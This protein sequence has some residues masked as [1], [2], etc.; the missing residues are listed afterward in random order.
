MTRNGHWHGLPSAAWDELQAVVERFES[1]W[2]QDRPARIED[3]LPKQAAQRLPVLV[4]LVHVDLELHFKAGRPVRVEDYLQRFPDLT[5]EPQLVAELVAAEYRLRRGRG[6]T[7]P[8]EEYLDRFPAHGDRLAQHLT[9]STAAG[10][11]ITPKEPAAAAAGLPAQLGHYLVEGEIARGGMGQVVRLRDEEFQRPLAMK[12]LLPG[13]APAAELAERFLRE[14]RLTGQLQHPGV[15]PVHELGHLPDGRPYFVMKLIKGHSLHQLLR[16]RLSRDQDLTRFVGIFEQVCQTLA[17]AHARGI[18]HRDLKP[19]NVMV[20]A[21]GEVQVMDWGLA[22]VLPREEAQSRE[23]ERPGEPTT[24]FGLPDTPGISGETAAGA[25]LGTLAYMA[26]EQA[27]GE[28]DRLDART[29]V[30]GLGAILCEV[31]TGRPPFAGRS[32]VDNHRKAMHGELTDALQRLDHCGADAELVALA[33]HCLAAAPDD[34]P[35]HAGAVAAAVAAYRAGVQE[36]LR[37]AEI[38]RAAADVRAAE[39]RKRRRVSRALAGVALLLVLAVAGG[40]L[41]YLQVQAAQL[42]RAELAE[43]DLEALLAELDRQRHDLHQRLAGPLDAAQL[44]G[45]I[46]S[47]QTRVAKLRDLW[48]RADAVWQSEQNLL[49]DTWAD[50]LDMAERQVRDEEKY[51]RWADRLDRLQQESFT[52]VDGKFP[53]ERV[54]NKY[55]AAFRAM[56]LDVQAGEPAAVAGEMTR[57]PVRHVLVAALDHWAYLLPTQSKVLPRVLA[58]ARRADP[59]PWQDRVR[60][61]GTWK[62][63][64][65]LLQLAREAPLE[66][67]T[68]QVLL[69]LATKLDRK[70]SGEAATLLRRALARHPRSFWLYHTLGILALNPT[71]A[72]GY[73]RT[74]VALRPDSPAAHLL[75]GNALF[76]QKDLDG[77]AA[78]YRAVLKLDPHHAVALSNLGSATFEKGDIEGAMRFYQKA[79]RFDQSLIFPVQNLGLIHLRKKEL[80]EALAYYQKA[81][82]LDRNYGPAHFGLGE[83][84]QARHDPEGALWHFRKAVALDPYFAPAHL[85]LANALADRRDLAGAIEHYRKALELDAASAPAC[86]GLG[87]ALR[88]QGDLSEAVFYYKKA[89]ALDPNSAPAHHNLGLALRDRKDLPGAIRHLRKAVELN[90][91]DVA[92]R[93]NLSL[94]LLDQGDLDGAI[95]ECQRTIE[96]DPKHLYAHLNLGLALYRKK[97]RKGAIE[98]YRRAVAIDPKY[99]LTRNNLGAT[100]VE[101]RDFAGAS[102]Q[103]RQALALDPN[104]AVAHNGLGYALRELG[105]LDGAIDHYRRALELDPSFVLAHGNLGSALLQAKDL[106]GAAR[107]FRKAVALDPRY[108]AAY[109]GLGEVL[110][111][112]KEFDEAILQFKKAIALDVNYAPARQGLDKAMRASKDLE[113]SIAPYEKAVARNP[114]SAT[115]HCNLGDAM[116]DR[117]KDLDGA[118]RHYQKAL[119]LDSDLIGALHGLGKI[120]YVKKDF[121]GATAQWQKVLA[122]D[123]NYAPA[124][125]NL[126]N[127]L[128]ARKDLNGAMRHYEKALAANPRL[129]AARYNLGVALRRKNDLDGAARQYRRAIALDPKYVLAHYSLGLVLRDQRDLA[130]ARS[131]CEKTL[132]LDPTHVLAYIF[133]GHVLRDQKDLD[134][135]ARCYRKALELDPRAATAHNGLGSVLLDRQDF[136]GAAKHFRKAIELDRKLTS[137]HY[138]LGAVLRE[139]RDL[140]GA[141]AQLR[142][143]LEVD[144][145]YFLAHYRLGLCLYDTRDFEGAARHYRRVIELNPR[146]IASHNS[147]GNTLRALGD[148]DGAAAAYRQALVIDPKYAVAHCNLG[149]I[150]S[151]RHDLD[152]AIRHYR[153]AVA[154]SPKFAMAHCNLGVALQKQGHF[155]EALKSLLE[156]HELGSRQ[157]DWKSPSGQWVSQCR[158]LLEL[159][160]KLPAILKGNAEP[161]D[162]AELLELADLCWRYKQLHAAAARFYAAAFAVEPQRATAAQRYRAACCAALAASGHGADAGQLPDGHKS[163]WRRQALDWLRAELAELTRQVAS[164]P[165]A[166]ATVRRTLQQWQ[167][168]PDLAGVR[169]EQALAPLPQVERQSW[170][171]FWFEV[172]GLLGRP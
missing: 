119:E 32:N 136:P 21:F 169:D 150:L 63:Q 103:Y 72:C 67:V 35:R 38:D 127:I 62:D 146:H 99:A 82:Q 135:A 49:P 158:R 122:R 142:R 141:I 26:P 113:A 23:C 116:L 24:V 156:G 93:Y 109:A 97:D 138:N 130:G 94:A 98:Y 47:W 34:R 111:A 162:A 48:Q 152:G 143:T 59:G 89:V 36:R 11:E 30:F 42:R 53:Y 18:I 87:N 105:D 8:L 54:A 155:A 22:K 5:N 78:E 55:P 14:A 65:R 91:K 172:Q 168:D 81:L 28:V 167:S 137:A 129:I 145:N 68:P 57:L 171:Q 134:G 112:G 108:T 7:P 86:L 17:Y 126:G 2:E 132:E 115:A 140:K 131:A 118:L 39:E 61:A 77:A 37:R 15:P 125:Y 84:C 3:F 88:T 148:L 92:G 41:W 124:H 120:L 19:L 149:V 20:G 102:E 123:P 106:D 163:R 128:L 164:N 66:R 33:K 43:R 133:L 9:D 166:A 121:D 31:L 71:E 160:E 114:Q 58:V 50:R 95:R 4:E 27:R 60:N 159:D 75:V 153:Q 104:C 79:R 157:P 85:G 56:G 170:Q 154:L 45:D 74:A 117:K 52:E 165:K 147:L 64:R 83:V 10:T 139:Q 70:S 161:R 73:G 1:T 40:T 51:W 144:P 69:L 44:F 107:H 16:A 101:S 13:G 90:P 76:R 29:D 12:V 100:L 110:A 6:G 96:L 46:G 151:D 25:V 80:D